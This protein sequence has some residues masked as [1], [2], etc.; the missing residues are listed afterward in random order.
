MPP[1]PSRMVP[2]RPH[3]KELLAF[4]RSLL[5]GP[6]LPGTSVPGRAGEWKDLPIQHSWVPTLLCSL[7]GYVLGASVSSSENRSDNSPSMKGPQRPNKATQEALAQCLTRPPC[8]VQGHRLAEPG[9][10]QTLDAPRADPPA[11]AT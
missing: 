4:S 9:C 11:L 10:T 7:L 5:C 1:A 8:A 3:D 2:A 6:A